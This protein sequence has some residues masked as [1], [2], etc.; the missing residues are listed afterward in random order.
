M[1]S[2]SPAT[3]ASE[4]CYSQT[5]FVEMIFPDQANHYGTLYGGNALGLLGK[6]AFVTATRYARHAVVMA[7]SERVEFH[8]PIR[9]GQMLEL[10]GRITRV[11]RSSMT[12]EVV[13]VAETLLTGERKE[14]LAGRF[15]MVAVDKEGRPH[16]LR[17]EA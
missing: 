6:A 10:T 17:A 14:A 15:E 3:S 9:L 2:V 4:H 1:T 16:P 12:V 11:G 13:G 8:V 5:T 7:M